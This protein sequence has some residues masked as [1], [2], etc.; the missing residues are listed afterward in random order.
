MCKKFSQAPAPIPLPADHHEVFSAL[1]ETFDFS[2]K[3]NI[4]LS[5]VTIRID[6]SSTLIPDLASPAAHVHSQRHAKVES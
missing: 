2:G 6:I 1:K 4:I 5:N 3:A